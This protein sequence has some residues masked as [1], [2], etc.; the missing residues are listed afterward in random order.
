MKDRRPPNRLANRVRLSGVPVERAR[1]SAV[2]QRALRIGFT[3]AELAEVLKIRDAGG[4]PCHRVYQLAQ[5]KLQGTAADISGLKR[6]ERN[7]KKV[8]SDWEKRIQRRGWRRLLILGFE[9]ASTTLQI[10]PGEGFNSRVQ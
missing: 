4:T 2:V 7:L 9:S 3:L 5:D 10:K 8:L 6:T 1:A